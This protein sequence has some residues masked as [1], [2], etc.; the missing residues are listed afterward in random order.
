MSTPAPQPQTPPADTSVSDAPSPQNSQSPLPPQTDDLPLIAGLREDLV[1]AG[2]TNDGVAE[3]LGAEAV[4]A[5]DREQVVPGQLRILEV[6]AAADRDTAT[7][8]LGSPAP[9]PQMPRHIA[10]ARSNTGLKSGYDVADPQQQRC[11]VLTA[12]W[13]VSLEVTVEQANIALPRIGV[14]GLQRLRL[15]EVRAGAG[16]GPDVVVPYADLR[17]YQIESASGQRNL[18]VTSDLS[19]HQV[20]GALP[21]DH[22][23]GIG[24]ASLTLAATTHRRPAATALDIGTG[25]GLQLLHLLS[26]CEHVTGTD[27]SQRAL[28][29]ARFNLL[30]NAD[31]LDLDPHRLSDR[32]ELLH[33]S[34]LEPLTGRSFDLVVSN[35]PFVITPRTVQESQTERYTYRDGGREGDGLM[36]EL[37]TGLPEVLR[38]GATAQMLGNWE[39]KADDVDWRARLRQWVEGTGLHAWF[40]QR[41]AQPP[42]EYAETWLRDASEERSINEYR[43]RYAAYL[44]DFEARGVEQIGFGLIWLQRPA[45]DTS[46]ANT[47]SANTAP[48]HR[49]EEILGPVQHPLGPVIGETTARMEQNDDVVLARTLVVPDSVTEERYQRFGAEHPEVIIARQ[50]SG[51]RRARPISS[52]AAGFMAAADGEYTAAQLITAVCSLTDTEEADL[53]REVLDLW[54][55]GFL[56]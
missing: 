28:D 2:F 1:E 7:A 23:L 55:Q 19:A 49:F 51:L 48:R 40:I 27:L 44:A 15:V 54:L 39:Q 22:V 10:S 29:F 36:A 33:G 17:P 25:C 43:R 26:H 38:P 32:V 6:L 46:T 8:P 13:L 31:A 52:A 47:A 56:S 37:I 41:D 16:R 18:W 53:R 11:A 14:D 35:P 21:H 50:G 20:S 34:L 30:I 42:A 5:L 4:A 24:Q 3:L 45:S 12:L 9:P